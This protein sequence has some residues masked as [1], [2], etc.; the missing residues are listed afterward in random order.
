MA[1]GPVSSTGSYTPSAQIEQS[2]AHRQR[3]QDFDAL[4]QAL[5]SG[6]LSGAKS[7]FAAIQQDIKTGTQT[8]SSHKIETNDQSP[9]KVAFQA[10]KDAIN[11]SDLSAAQSAFSTLE[12]LRDQRRP[13]QRADSTTS[14]PAASST[15]IQSLSTG[16]SVQA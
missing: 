10:L 1:V 5:R 12:Q 16:I 8:Q 3:R 6:D 2:S 9:I 14:A 4:S 13:G 7:A 11:S 15:S